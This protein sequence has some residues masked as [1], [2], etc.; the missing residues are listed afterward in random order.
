MGDVVEQSVVIDA[1]IER[2]WDV[3]MDPHR[4]GEWVTIHRS[5]SDVPAGPLTAGSSFKQQMRLKRVPLEV[6]W[7][8]ESCQP[9]YEATWIGKAAAG[10]RAR[11]SYRL[12]E[13]EGS[14]RF[15][16]ENE[17]ELPAGPLGRVAGRAFNAVSGNHEA[18]KTLEALK[19]LLEGR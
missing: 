3:I 4:L 13:I 7:Q 9:P 5:V 14:T 18:R 2:V 6:Q 10:A 19:R 17:F 11:I 1:P 15:D 8:V 16:Y 12:S